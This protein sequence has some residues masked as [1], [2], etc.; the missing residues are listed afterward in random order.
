MDEE[1]VVKW[2]NN[3]VTIWLYEDRCYVRDFLTEEYFRVGNSTRSKLL[4]VAK[5]QKDVEL[6]LGDTAMMI[7]NKAR[8]AW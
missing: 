8:E 2:E 5:V 1:L 3:N 6:D 7:I 4:A